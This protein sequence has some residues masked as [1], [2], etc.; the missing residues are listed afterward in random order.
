M[1]YI[2]KFEWNSRKYNQKMPL[3]EICAQFTKTM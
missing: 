3:A 1:E 2:K